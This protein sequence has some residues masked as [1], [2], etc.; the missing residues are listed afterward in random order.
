M[1]SINLSN[2]S[3]ELLDEVLSVLRFYTTALKQIWDRAELRNPKQA[4]ISQ[5]RV[6]YARWADESFVQ[7]FTGKILS[8][9][10]PDSD[11]DACTY[12]ENPK[13]TGWIRIFFGDDMVDISFEKFAHLIKSV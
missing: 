12:T 3:P 11:K 4:K 8:R 5:V 6:E 10:F 2:Y 1:K 13:I 7:S 9:F